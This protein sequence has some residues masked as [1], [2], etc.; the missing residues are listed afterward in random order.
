MRKH[1]LSPEVDIHQLEHSMVVCA[2]TTTGDVQN[3]DSSQNFWGL[4]SEIF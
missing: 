4:G 1:Y 3:Y 2:S